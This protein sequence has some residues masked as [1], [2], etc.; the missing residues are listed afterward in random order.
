[1]S[2]AS[3]QRNAFDDDLCKLQRFV[4]LHE[5]PSSTPIR[6]PEVVLSDVA[7]IQNSLDRPRTQSNG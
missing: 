4:V 7:G 1:M 5:Q 3:P 6:C 2:A